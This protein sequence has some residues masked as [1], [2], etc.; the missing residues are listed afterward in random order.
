MRKT[1]G[2]SSIEVDNGVHTFL[3]RE[4]LHREWEGICE[5]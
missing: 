4:R 3:A 5:C 1:P 2:Y